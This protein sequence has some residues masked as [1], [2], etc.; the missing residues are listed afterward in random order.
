[1]SLMSVRLKEGGW[2]T[3]SWW[4]DEAADMVETDE[5][6]SLFRFLH[7]QVD[8]DNEFKLLDLLGLMEKQD[9]LSEL[10]NMLVG[11]KQCMYKLLLEAQKETPEPPSF[12]HLELSWRA[13]I[14]SDGD[15]CKW[16]S[17]NGV[18]FPDEDMGYAKDEL[19]PYGLDFMPICKIK[20]LPLKL[21]TDF[22]IYDERETLGNAPVLINTSQ[23]FTLYEVLFGVFNE[24]SF[25]G[26]PE[27]RD[28]ELNNLMGIMKEIED[29]TA[30]LIS[31]DEVKAK[32]K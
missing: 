26:D 31:W 11:S 5:T 16:S 22:K 10:G 17:F 8:L 19:I 13:S 4:D 27:E 18:G 6:K 32:L 30:D 28:K 1:M 3:A 15:F 23:T 14:D 29:G 9:K 24:L 12:E 7:Q 20:H 21:R 25:Y 2:L